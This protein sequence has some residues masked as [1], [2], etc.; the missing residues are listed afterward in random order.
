MA[1]IRMAIF[2]SSCWKNRGFFETH[3]EDLVRLLEEKLVSVGATD[4]GVPLG[5]LTLRPVILNLQQFVSCSPG[6]HILI[7]VPGRC[8]LGPVVNLWIC[9]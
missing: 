5:F 9:L 8:L 2:L 3:C 4:D 1:Y 6:F 7:L